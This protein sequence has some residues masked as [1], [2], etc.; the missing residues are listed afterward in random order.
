MGSAGALGTTGRLGVLEAN[1]G[2][3]PLAALGA[4]AVGGA[5]ALIAGTGAVVFLW[6]ASACVLGL[7][8]AQKMVVP[9][10]TARVSLIATTSG[11]FVVGLVSGQWRPAVGGLLC[12]I[13][14][15]CI[16][17]AC[18]LALPRRLGFGDVRMACLVGMGVGALSPGVA[19]AALAGAPLAGGLAGRRRGGPVP[20]PLAAFLGA[21][22]LAG[23]ILGAVGGPSGH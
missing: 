23:A 3:G 9:T 17:G 7:I 6:A 19:V 16:Y 15:G 1:F 8:D 5:A 22:G 4:A 21:F 13:A 20:V 18:A 10:A 11:L 14:A 2:R 12:A